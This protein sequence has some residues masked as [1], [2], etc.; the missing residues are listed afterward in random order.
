MEEKCLEFYFSEDEY[1]AEKEE[2]LIKQIKREERVK[3]VKIEVHKNEWGTYVVKAIIY[4]RKAGTIFA[5][6]EERTAIDKE[7]KSGRLEEVIFAKPQNIKEM[8]NRN[9]KE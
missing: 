6:E 7:I 2:E 9:T 3:N 1:N 5:D 8:K 4:Q